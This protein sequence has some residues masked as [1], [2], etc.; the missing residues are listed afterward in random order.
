[1]KKGTQV[2]DDT[3]TIYASGI[4]AGETITADYTAIKVKV[5]IDGKI[6]EVSV[7]PDNLVKTIKDAIKQKEGIDGGYKLIKGG[8]ILDETKTISE[9]G[10]KGG[11]TIVAD[12]NSI[13]INIKLGTKTF[14]IE[15][16]PDNKVKTIKDAIKEKQE[17]ESD[18]YT[19][20]KGTV[21][22]DD[23]KTIYAS[24]IKAGETI[25]AD[26][27]TIS[28]TVHIGEDKEI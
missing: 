24:G 13:T 6:V 3:K 17:V 23:S 2:L 10:L 14:P 8:A 26:Q 19:L 25:T 27:N 4:K 11:S 15:V 20:K 1:L 12:F 16:D 7:D 18:V 28:I 21:V 5:D 22:L 9:S